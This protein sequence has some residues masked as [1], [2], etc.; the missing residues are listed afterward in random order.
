LVAVP[1]EVAVL[2]E[3]AAAVGRGLAPQQQELLRAFRHHWRF[4]R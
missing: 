2:L 4:V 1:A 3:Q